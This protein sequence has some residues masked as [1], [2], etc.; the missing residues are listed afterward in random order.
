MNLFSRFRVNAPFPSDSATQDPPHLIPV[1]NHLSA[2]NKLDETSLSRARRVS[3]ESGERLAH[4]LTRLGIVSEQDL[5]EAYAA[6][7]GFPLISAVE[8]PPSPLLENQFNN[9]FLQAALVIPIDIEAGVMVVAMADPLDPQ[10]LAALRFAAGTDIRPKIACAGD[11]ETALGRLYGGSSQETLNQNAEKLEAETEDVDRLKDVASEAPIIRL[12]NQIINKAVEARASD[13]HIEPMDNDLKIRFRIDGHLR[14]MEAPHHRLGAALVSRVKIL[15]KLN[16]AERRL[17][18]DGR[19]RLAVRGKEVDFRVSTTPT[20]FGESVVLRIL[21]RG[22]LTLDF[23]ELGFDPL[24]LA[25]FRMVLNRPHGILL[26]TGPTGSGKTTTLYTSLHELNTPDKKI[27]TIEDPVEYQLKGINQVQ[28]K[29]QIGLTFANALRSFLRQDPD[30]MMIGEIRDLET[31]QIAIQAALT[32]HL[33]LSTLHTNNA[34]SAVTRLLDMGVE[35]FLL[36]STINGLVSQRLVRR[37]CSH[38]REPHYVLP[39][40][41]A[42]LHLPEGAQ[43]YRAIGC[44]AC[45]G[46]GYH[47]RTSILEIL[48]MTDVIRQLVLAHAE[49]SKIQQAAERDGMESMYA[50]GMRKVAQGETTIEEVLRVTRETP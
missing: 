26:V 33:V 32:G 47:G 48:Q 5:A 46:T 30:I 45:N 7:S 27:L 43:V 11:I 41:S 23:D 31:A 39:R 19:I 21:D 24:T 9:L 38:C 50:Y 34:A 44:A 28:V 12:V 20:I 37:L 49:A 1:L 13:I 35:D 10:T 22:H 2:A 3:S 40:E 6:I 15:A 25:R 29:P 42:K 18:Q 16:I 8:F 4:V 36:T 14:E 17:A